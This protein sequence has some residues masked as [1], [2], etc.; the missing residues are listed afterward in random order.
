MSASKLHPAARTKQSR[1]RR[2]GGVSPAA[3]AGGDPAVAPGATPQ[4][5]DNDTPS[6]GPIDVEAGPESA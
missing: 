6:A 2:L 4:L 3:N 5:A 1:T